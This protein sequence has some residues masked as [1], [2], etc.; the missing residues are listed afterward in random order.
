[1][2]SVIATV[3]MAEVWSDRR[4][5]GGDE[6]PSEGFTVLKWVCGGVGQEG[7]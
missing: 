2:E 4:W 6:A 5:D 7:S 1:M 3:T